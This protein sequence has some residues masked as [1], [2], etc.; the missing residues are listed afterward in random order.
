MQITDVGLEAMGGYFYNSDNDKIFPGVAALK[1]EN[2]V[3]QNVWKEEKEEVDQT[4][5]RAK[6]MTADV[7]KPWIK[8]V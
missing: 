1:R 4:Q 5:Q 3:F 8:C 7:P 2:G 6:F